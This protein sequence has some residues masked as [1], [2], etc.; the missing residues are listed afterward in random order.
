MMATENIFLDMDDAEISKVIL[1]NGALVGVK[2][3][4]SIGIQTKKCARC[5]RDVLYVLD[6]D[7]NLLCVG[8][9]VE[10]G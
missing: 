9:L 3:K 2:S 7:R 5:I 8:Q 6:L 1:G 10:N 4:G